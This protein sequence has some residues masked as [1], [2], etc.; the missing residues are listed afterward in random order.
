MPH[1][2]RDRALGYLTRIRQLTTE[3]HFRSS[4]PIWP[5]L[6]TCLNSRKPLL[7]NLQCLEI[8]YF[9]DDRNE[10]LIP[11]LSPSL[12]TLLIQND[13]PLKVRTI[14]NLAKVSNCDLEHF[15]YDGYTSQR[16]FEAI[17]LFENLQSV[18]LSLY[19]K[20]S[21]KVSVTIIKFL[22]SLP[23]LRSLTCVLGVFS[24]FMDGDQLRHISLQKIEIEAQ[25]NELHELFHRC[26][27]PSVTNV[28]ILMRDEI[29][30]FEGLKMSCPNTRKLD[31]DIFSLGRDY[32][33]R[34]KW[35]AALRSLPI[36]TFKLN[37]FYH[38]L[39]PSDLRTFAE[40][41]PDLHSF[42]IRSITKFDPLLSFPIFSNLPYLD[43]FKV[44]MPLC[45]LL[46]NISKVPDLVA[47]YVTTQGRRSGL[48]T[49]HF[50]DDDN[51]PRPYPVILAAEKQMLVKYMLLL[52][53]S[54]EGFKFSG[55]TH[56]HDA[57]FQ[58][59]QLE[60]G[61]ILSKLREESEK[62]VT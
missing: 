8:E 34:F 31:L 29:S 23:S 41:W 16:L 48:R 5:I 28:K 22:T 51:C 14:L 33:M 24:P 50:E 49:L 43:Y 58:K 39:T 11:L 46:S 9:S 17:M 4:E 45:H 35:L 18:K 6:S 54:L 52:F 26:V 25:V 53:P 10:Y 20:P 32:P 59:D 15:A 57:L 7:P 3:H 47:T 62:T 2:A 56:S 27:F 55:S 1:A 61:E 13:H 21:K 12:K 36:Q 19:D 30:S 42:Q 40:S 60:L 38:D 37:V 44:H